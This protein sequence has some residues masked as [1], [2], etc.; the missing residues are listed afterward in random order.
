MGYHPEGWRPPEK[1]WRSGFCGLRAEKWQHE[2][3]RAVNAAG[4]ACICECHTRPPAVLL[5][6]EEQNSPEWHALRSNG[7]GGSEIAAVVG[8]SPW[9]SRFALW[10]R[11]RGTL[12]EQKANDGMRWGTLLEPVVCDVWASL[13][14]DLDAQEAGTYRHAE[15]TWQLANVDRLLFDDEFLPNP[16]GLL[17]VKTAHQYDAHEWGNGPEDIP[18][19]YRCQVLWYMDVLG[20]PEA[21]LAVLIGGSDYREY[22]IPYA[23]DE[24]A[25]LREEGAKFWA[26]VQ[27]GTPPKIDEHDATYQAVREL[28]PE[29][30]GE[31]IDLPADLYDAYADTKATAEQAT[32][33]HRKAKAELLEAMGDAKRALV[34]GV[35]VLRRQPG[36]GGSVSLQP[37]PQPKHKES[38]A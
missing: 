16:V 20:V 24:A 7:L 12:G 27:D 21:H 4:I 14:P 30:D 15:R 25:W 1:G 8:L 5:G 36:R 9:T 29:I 31:D 13:H 6:R 11:K 38:A 28:H 19:Y 2:K 3:C 34:A 18:P 26:E 23:P 10:H 37:I 17:E 22:L 35:P 32:A 33:E